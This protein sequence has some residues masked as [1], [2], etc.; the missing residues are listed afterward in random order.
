KAESI[1]R[2]GGFKLGNILSIDEGQNFYPYRAYE[3]LGV[4]GGGIAEKSLPA[5][6][7]EP[8]SQEIKINVTLRYEIK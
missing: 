4:G 2:A 6:Q 3:S 8:G 5:P 7:I 1:A